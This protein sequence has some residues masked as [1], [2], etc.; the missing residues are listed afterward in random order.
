MIM[1]ETQ[2]A[3]V[4]QLKLFLTRMGK[5]SKSIIVGDVTQSDIGYNG[6]Q[7]AIKNL[8]GLKRLAICSFDKSDIMRH[9]IIPEILEKF[10]Q[11]EA[12]KGV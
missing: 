5:K 3:T 9:P 2:N 8:K 6:L 11:D 10:E 4:K 7:F 1:D 12:R